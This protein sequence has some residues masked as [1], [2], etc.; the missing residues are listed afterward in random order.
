MIK[1][2][3]IITLLILASGIA[4]RLAAD[5][6]P[7]PNNILA[8]KLVDDFTAKY[9]RLITMGIHAKRPNSS[10]YVIVAHTKRANIGN[11]SESEDTDAMT[12][13]K[14][15][16]PEPLEGGQYNV[17]LALHD[18]AAKTI[19]ALVLHVKPAVT[20]GSDGKAA[21]LR[22]STQIRDDLAGKIPSEDK[23]FV[24]ADAGVPQKIFA[25][26]LAEDEAAKHP[27][28]N[29][30]GFHVNPPNSADNII[31]AASN[32]RKVGKKSSPD[33]VEV[34]TTGKP[35]VD[36]RVERSLTDVGLP[37]KDAQGT[38]IGMVVMEVK[39][40]YTKDE[41]VAL[42]RAQQILSEIEKQVPTKD[43][44]FETAKTREL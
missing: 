21:A 9:L 13:G 14:P 33:D 8:Q 15:F 11:K 44:L 10:E 32:S 25:Q 20:P 24:E 3:A 34:I 41:K 28:V 7:P 40:S 22:L 42:K 1:R 19:G 27:E 31:I 4:T 2:T 6:A 23:L 36:K 39:F 26:K 35:A 30:V 12:S 18:V 5:P 37:L 17:I 16:G 38:I 43:K 29:I